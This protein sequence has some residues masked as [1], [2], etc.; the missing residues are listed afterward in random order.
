[1]LTTSAIYETKCVIIIIV[2]ASNM[3]LWT[4]IYEAY[5]R[6]V[7]YPR[8]QVTKIDSTDYLLLCSDDEVNN[9]QVQWSS[10]IQ[11]IEKD[12][13]ICMVQINSDTKYRVYNTNSIYL[14]VEQKRNIKTVVHIYLLW[15][16]PSHPRAEELWP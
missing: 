5:I 4:N 15:H 2:V 1:M 7:S 14:P 10:I 16:F 6:P 12:G 3:W 8:N 9:M 13:C 11:L